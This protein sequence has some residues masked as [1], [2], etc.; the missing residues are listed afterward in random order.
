MGIDRGFDR[1][2]FLKLAAAGTA[3]VLLGPEATPAQAINNPNVPRLDLEAILSLKPNQT[4]EVLGQ[5]YRAEVLPVSHQ[6]LPDG[7]ALNRGQLLFVDLGV[8][9][10]PFSTQGGLE[11]TD[12][13][14]MEKLSVCD[15][16]IGL[17]DE[18]FLSYFPE[19]RGNNRFQLGLRLDDE[20]GIIL[21]TGELVEAGRTFNQATRLNVATFAD[22]GTITTVNRAIFLTPS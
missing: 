13:Q 9:G 2:T 10:E 11:L 15:D 18:T 8:A 3:A 1:R 19:Q 21:P 7:L 16:R 6:T 20:L 22:P 12:G 14:K 17:G 4:L 5:S